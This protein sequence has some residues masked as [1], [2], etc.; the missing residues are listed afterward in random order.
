MKIIFMGTPDFAV[1]ALEALAK[2]HTIV[3]VYTQPPRP[4]GRG[5]QMQKS[6]V[7][8]KADELGFPVFT[9]ENFK[10]ESDI[11]IFKNLN[12]DMAVV[13]AYGLILPA[14]IF[15][16]PRLNT[17]N[18]HASLL[19]RWRGADPI[20]RAVM[21][22]DTETGVCIMKVE[23]GLDTG[24]IYLSE[25]MPIL[26]EDTSQTV[27]DILSILGANLIMEYL[28]NH[29]TL[30][31]VPQSTEGITYASKLSKEEFKIDWTKPADVIY[32]LI[33]ATYPVGA[34]FETEQT[35]IK[36]KEASL[37]N[38]KTTAKPGTIL[39]PDL[40]IACGNGTVLRLETLQ[41]S[42]KQAMPREEFLKG[43]SLNKI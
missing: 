1:P 35:I 9:P 41:R 31:G 13:A 37:L 28:E 11:E 14:C 6:A 10:N 25:T 3:G 43:F 23:K 26:P 36:V 21:E 24:E 8:Q 2:K 18:I 27:H 7:H 38:E 40:K 17:V 4:A 29:E 22:G 33:R 34:F 32:N 16:A 12:A 20:R 5:Y 42:G 39:S 15:E 30:T 19:P